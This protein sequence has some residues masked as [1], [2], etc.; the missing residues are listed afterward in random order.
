MERRF[1]V[2]R[3]RR[4]GQAR[5]RTYFFLVFLSLVLFNNPSLIIFPFQSGGVGRRRKGCPSI[6]HS[7]WGQDTVI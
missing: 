6:T 5:P 3:A 7:G 2:R 4:T 1:W